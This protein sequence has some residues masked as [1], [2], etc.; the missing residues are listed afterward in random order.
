MLAITPEAGLRA[1]V[2]GLEVEPADFAGD[3]LD[4][5]AW[6]LKI[7]TQGSI[8]LFGEEGSKAIDLVDNTNA[9]VAAT[10]TPGTT[11]DV[12][13]YGRIILASIR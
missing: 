10:I 5:T 3:G 6:K 9:P 1:T 12:D 11:F 8:D 7:R 2:D 13:A 4:G